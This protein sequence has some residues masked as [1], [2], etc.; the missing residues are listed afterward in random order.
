M[1]KTKPKSK[2]GAKSAKSAHQPAQRL[3]TVAVR[4]SDTAKV[5]TYKI[6]PG[7][8]K[9]GDELIA[10]TDRGPVVVFVVRI[11]QA[12]QPVP[13]VEL[14]TITRKAVPI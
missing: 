7:R 14:K 5:Y 10:D 1:S 2:A 9:L 11:D 12:V 4:F 13:G 6:K 8:V 3:T